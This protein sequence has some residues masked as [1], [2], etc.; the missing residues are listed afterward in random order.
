MEPIK[1]ESEPVSDFSV[2]FKIPRS[3]IDLL[4]AEATREQRSRT[5]QVIRILQERYGLVEAAEDTERM[6]A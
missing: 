1:T 5:R 2:L 3:L 4:D 6:T